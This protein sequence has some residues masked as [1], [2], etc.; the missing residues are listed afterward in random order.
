M[1]EKVQGN[2]KKFDVEGSVNVQAPSK[3]VIIAPVPKVAKKPNATDV[4]YEEDIPEPS[5]LKLY[6]DEVKSV[7]GLDA[8]GR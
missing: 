5:E 1:I 7:R 4:I 3:E 8:R 6:L 2:L